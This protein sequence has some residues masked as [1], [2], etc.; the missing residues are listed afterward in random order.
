M[1]EPSPFPPLP[2]GVTTE[3]FERRF[4]LGIFIDYTRLD[5]GYRTQTTLQQLFG[6]LAPMD[7][8]TLIA[9]LIDDTRRSLPP[10]H[11]QAF[12]ASLKDTLDNLGSNTPA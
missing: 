2:E 5:V 1:S 11:F 6:E 12:A 8:I 9:K 4:V 7:A 3:R 10:D